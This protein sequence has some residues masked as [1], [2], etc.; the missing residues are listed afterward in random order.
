[1]CCKQLFQSSNPLSLIP[2]HLW[3]LPGSSSP[4]LREPQHK[5]VNIPIGALKTILKEVGND[6]VNFEF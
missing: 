5:V 4:Y 1:M 6:V 2:F 3:S